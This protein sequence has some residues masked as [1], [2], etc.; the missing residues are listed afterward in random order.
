MILVSSFRSKAHLQG[1]I[2]DDG[3]CDDDAE[4]EFGRR[5]YGAFTV[6]LRSAVLCQ[7]MARGLPSLV[8]TVADSFC[9]NTSPDE[10]VRAEAQRQVQA[11]NGTWHSNRVR[12]AASPDPSPLPADGRSYRYKPSHLPTWSFTAAAL[13]RIRAMLQV[14]LQLAVQQPPSQVV[15]HLRVGSTVLHRARSMH[16][17][18]DCVLECLNVGE[19]RGL[20]RICRVL[21]RTI[22]SV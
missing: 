2:P 10:K 20:V 18:A 15:F 11:V 1:A 21:F 16:V 5:W 3:C 7:A 4:M 14:W 19:L 22:R 6:R 13:T 17:Q 12:S 9:L 8:A